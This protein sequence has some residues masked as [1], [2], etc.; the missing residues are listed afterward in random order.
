MRNGRVALL[1]RKLVAVR[2]QWYRTGV[3]RQFKRC[4][5]RRSGRY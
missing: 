5:N 3:L 1:T 4:K 2:K